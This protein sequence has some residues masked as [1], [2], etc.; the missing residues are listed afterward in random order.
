MA[1]M[2]QTALAVDFVVTMDFV[3]ILFSTAATLSATVLMVLTKVTVQE[4]RA[5]LI[6]G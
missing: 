4:V 5:L 2:K 3:P 6:K 1:L